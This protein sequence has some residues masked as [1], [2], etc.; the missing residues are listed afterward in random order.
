MRFELALSKNKLVFTLLALLLVS[1]SMSLTGS[2][3][4]AYTLHSCAE[5]VEIAVHTNVSSICLDPYELESACMPSGSLAGNPVCSAIS[6]PSAIRENFPLVENYSSST[7]Q[8]RNSQGT[9]GGG[10]QEVIEE[11]Q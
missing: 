4:R 6:S 2:F 1:L 8:N 9:A 10:E 11:G 7:V 5:G 3:Q